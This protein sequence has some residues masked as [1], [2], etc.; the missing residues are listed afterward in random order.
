VHSRPR[1][2]A[3]PA[4]AG[5]VRVRAAVAAAAVALLA[6]PAQTATADPVSDDDVARAQAA[7]RSTAATVASV[8]LALA[9]Q[10]AAL[11]EAWV[12]V[13]RAAEDY[14]AALVERDTAAAQAEAAAE[15]ARAAAEDAEAA[16]AE[17]GAIA[18]EAYRSGG[19][20][21]GVAAMLSSSDYEEYVARSEAIDRLGQRADRAVQRYE[22]AD[23]V[24]GS[25]A[26]LAERAAQEAQEAA[27]E[28]ERAL[29]RAQELQAAAEAEVARIEAER[30]GLLAELARLRQTSV[31]LERQRQ[32]QL[33]A[34]RQARADAAARAGHGGGSGG[35]GSGG[36]GSGGG[37]NP[38]AQPTN[39]P[40]QPT[41][42][43]A[44]PTNPPAQPTNP[45][46][47]PTPPPAS[48]PYGLGTGSQRGT[49]AQGQAAV[50]WALQQVGKDYLY[51][52]S[53]PD[54]FDCSGLTM[55]AW[56]AAGVNLNRTSR[57][58]YR[59]VYKIT[60]DS[61]RPGD[62]VFFG[63]NPSDPGSVYHVAMYIGN[64]QIVEAPRAGVPVRVTSMR[65]A[66]TMPYAGRP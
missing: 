16:R 18:L 6:L 30:E 57:D 27:A 2:A 49:A 33:D 7:V 14:T 47:P 31:E 60:Y 53:G 8:E 48:D 52:G 62:L 43:P 3:R 10:S 17:L 29:T 51:G 35:S 64:N 23:V 20:L 66:N 25:L 44:Q 4:Q 9:Q 63:D 65:W 11:E 15:R 41:N 45:P 37:A 40:A 19:A 36:S 34:E 58:Q 28:A 12:A 50:A 56:Q 39:P 54:A 59:Q 5:R 13:A 22:A 26:A 32:A 21:D 24:N 42:P 46:A 55:R 38:P 61:M 1:A